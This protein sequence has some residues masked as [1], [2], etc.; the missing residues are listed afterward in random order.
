MRRILLIYSLILFSGWQVVHAQVYDSRQ[1]SSGDQ[2]D[3]N[4]IQMDPSMR[5]ENPDSMNVQVEGLAPDIY[6][7]W[8]VYERFGNIIPI[9]FD[10][11][12]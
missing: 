4:N 9:P 2:F 10:T 3:P 11:V 6:K 12:Y 7:M 1:G 8:N 5:P